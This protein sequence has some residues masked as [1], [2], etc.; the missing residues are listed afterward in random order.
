MYPY[1]PEPKYPR[2]GANCE[3]CDEH[4]STE[5]DWDNHQCPDEG[6]ED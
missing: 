1:P 5:Y 3:E 2:E 4:C 6:D